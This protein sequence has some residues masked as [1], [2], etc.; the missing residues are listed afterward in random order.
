[1]HAKQ[2]LHEML[3][4]V[5]HLK[6]L[7]TLELLITGL[8]NDKKLSVTQLGRSLDNDAQEKNNI[9]RSDRFLSNPHIWSER[10][11]IY[12]AVSLS[13]IDNNRRPLIIVDWSHVPNTTCYI[14]R[15]A[16]AAKGRALTLY[17]EVFPKRLENN[18]HVHQRFLKK[19]QKLIPD[20]S[21]PILITDAGFGNPWF[22]SVQDMGWDYIGRVRGT[23]CFRINDDENTWRSYVDYCQSIAKQT[24][25]Y[26]GKG[27]LTKKTPFS[28]HFY[29]TK[30]PKKY[31][32]SLNKLKKKSHYKK[33]IEHSR[34]A[35]EP[36]LLATSLKRM[37][38]TIIKLY[39][40]R[41]E[42]E[43]GF[44]DLKSSQFGFSFE[45]AYSIK[46][47]R[48][49]V[50]LMIA[51]LAAYIL[52]FIGWIAEKNKWHYKF[53]ANTDKKKRVLSL[54]YL[55]C[56]VVKKKL[57]IIKSAIFKAFQE[58]KNSPAWSW[59]EI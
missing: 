39:F 22:Q 45:H 47:R 54:F 12:Q 56:R 30:L 35:N 29:L 7:E 32:V 5:M 41:M 18:P 23:K 3:S 55:G 52:F 4:P 51:M 25:V 34:A 53:Q 43:E 42:I 10:F 21:I 11:N 46:I 17:E 19:I 13:L 20:T 26:L 50:L 31:R 57:R 37:P 1:M 6:R 33:D 38:E 27:D 44:R 28:T 8:M 2:F 49:Q 9:K 24:P 40:L 16:L 58:L 14:L 48:I 36:W 15:A 59:E